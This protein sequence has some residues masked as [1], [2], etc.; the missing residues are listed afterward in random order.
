MSTAERRGG[1]TLHSARP[2]GTS[3]RTSSRRAKGSRRSQRGPRAARRSET[4]PR[5]RPR[6]ALDAVVDFGAKILFIHQ[7]TLEW[8]W[9][10]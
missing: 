9:G 1:P 10:Y 4:A 7:E 2:Q 5:A 6:A 3:S 8:P